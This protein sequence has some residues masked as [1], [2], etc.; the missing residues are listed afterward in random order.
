MQRRIS[1]PSKRLIGQAN[2]A[3]RRTRNLRS[4]VLTPWVLPGAALLALIALAGGQTVLEQ[5]FG[6]NSSLSIVVNFVGG[7]VFIALL[8]REPRQ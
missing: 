7:I 6:F 5:V 8:V 2:R 1:N 3:V 4:G